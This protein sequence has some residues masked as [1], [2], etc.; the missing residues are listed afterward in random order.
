MTPT[1]VPSIPMKRN[2]LP[3]AAAASRPM[4]LVT[5]SLTRKA[6][7]VVRRVTSRSNDRP[8]AISIFI[9]SG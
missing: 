2:L 9:V 7:L 3:T 8:A 4:S 5:S 6:L 1:I